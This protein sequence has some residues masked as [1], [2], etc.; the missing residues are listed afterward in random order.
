MI[1]GQDEDDVEGDGPGP[2]GRWL[3]TAC[4]DAKLTQGSLAELA[5]VSGQQISNIETGRTR[6]P[7]GATRNK[8]ERASEE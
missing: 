3:R 6:H 2:S 8:L 5:G 1:T 4:E 7:Q